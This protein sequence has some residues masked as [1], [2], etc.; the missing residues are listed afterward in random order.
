LTRRK[1]HDIDEFKGA[2]MKILPTMEKVPGNGVG[3]QLA[4]WRDFDATM[5]GAILCIHGL[6]ANLQ[7]WSQ[8]AESLRTRHPLMAMDLRGRGHSDQPPAGYCL[9]A[10]VEDIRCVLDALKIDRITLMGHSLGAYIS[11]AFAAAY[12]ERMDRLILVDGG[13]DLPP[14]QWELVNQAIKPALA[15]LGKIFPSFEEYVTPLKNSP[16]FQPW[17]ETLESYFRYEIIAVDGGVRS[18]IN[19]DHIWEEAENLAKAD[20]AALYPQVACP[21]LIMRATEGLFIKED[22]VLP[23]ETAGSMVHRIPRARLF[24]V[25]GT[26]HYSIVFYPHAGRDGAIA[27]FVAGL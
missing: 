21:T 6:S 27:D 17:T 7:C 5:P 2:T 10:H 4:C 14:E 15:R 13:G 12:P 23:V 18:R 9:A 26:N 19:P 1:H 25:A 20:I 22:V 3:I 16:L 8:M 24:D 11:L